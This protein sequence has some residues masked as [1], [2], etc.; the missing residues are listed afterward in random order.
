MKTER[1]FEISRWEGKKTKR[2]KRK[3]WEMIKEGRNSGNDGKREREKQKREKKRKK[4]E[5]QFSS[6]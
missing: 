1:D 4:V 5:F 6:A 2:G 3:L